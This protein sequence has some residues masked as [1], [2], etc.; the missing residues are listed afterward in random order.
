RLPRATNADTGILVCPKLLRSRG[1]FSAFSFHAEDAQG[2]IRTFVTHAWCPNRTRRSTDFCS[3]L[4]VS[5]RAVGPTVA[6][7][8]IP[9]VSHRTVLA[10]RDTRAVADAADRRRCALH[11]GWP[12]SPRSV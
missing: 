11:R 4:F 3:K 1:R 7:G 5:C 9:L 10:S 8:D 2:T 12:A 6:S